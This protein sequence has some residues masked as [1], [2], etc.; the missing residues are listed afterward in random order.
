M[1]DDYLT[2][3]GR[4]LRAV[5][6]RGSLRCRVLA[7]SIDHL[8][9]DPDALRRFG[10]AHEVANAFAAELG[11]RASRRA[12][13]GAFAALAAAG[14]V[15]A[16]AFVGASFAG[17]PD[18]DTFPVAALVGFAAVVF[19]PQIAFVAGTLAVVRTLRCRALV[20]PSSE[21]RII[22]RRTGLALAGGLVTMG[23]L[24]LF[25][26]EL[27]GEIATW[28]VRSTIL[29]A[30]AA[31][32]LL[33]LAAIPAIRATRLRPQVAGQAGDI[34][35]DLGLPRADPW[36]F[37]LLVALIVGLMVAIAGAVQGD[38]LDGASRGFAEALACLGGFAVF[39]RYLGLRS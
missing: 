7:E 24:A 20:I 15:Y 28:W 39:G 33:L 13:V 1:I 10:S 36:R 3:L 29:G 17:I 27:R 6:I 12:A 38:P 19:A 2:E 14:A 22:N 5:G 9:S 25:A 31:S 4:E 18:P 11:A 8:S 26:F 16:V 34:F 23:A 35:D 32:G 30:A 21:L 37:A